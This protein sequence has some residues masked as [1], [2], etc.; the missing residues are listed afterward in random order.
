[1]IIIKLHKE[2]YDKNNKIKD[3]N[4]KLLTNIWSVCFDVGMVIGFF[5]CNWLE[6]TLNWKW[7]YLVMSGL[8]IMLTTTT[9][10][11]LGLRSY[12]EDY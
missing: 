5:G 12:I 6:Y 10:L 9:A 8:I 3:R 1:M 7:Q 11:F 2:I 4:Y